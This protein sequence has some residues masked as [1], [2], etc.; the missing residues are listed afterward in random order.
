ML[1]E[2]SAESPTGRGTKTTRDNCTCDTT[3][4]CG[5]HS[6]DCAGRTRNG[7]TNTA[8]YKRTRK[9]TSLLVSNDLTF[10]RA[11][12]GACLFDL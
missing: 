9:F 8:S 2:L 11:S 6:E 1:S 7:R 12:S 4:S 3:Y 10:V 5:S